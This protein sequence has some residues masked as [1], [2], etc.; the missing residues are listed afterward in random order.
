MKVRIMP[1]AHRHPAPKI[2][3]EQQLN[4]KPLPHTDITISGIERSSLP[5]VLNAPPGLDG[6][7]THLYFLR[8]VRSLA[9]ADATKDLRTRKAAND[10]EPSS[11]LRKV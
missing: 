4:A 3:I 7:V 11:D 5:A 1:S 2:A 9:V 10:N 8:F 6:H